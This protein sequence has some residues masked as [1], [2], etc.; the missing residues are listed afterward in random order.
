MSAVICMSHNL[1]MRV[2]AVGVESEDQ[3]AL[4][5]SY[6]CDEIQGDLISKPL[7]VRQFESLVANS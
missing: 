3:F 6:G 2:N 1:R 4:V 7:P 5:R